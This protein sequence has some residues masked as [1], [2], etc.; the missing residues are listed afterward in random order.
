MRHKTEPPPPPPSRD[1][2]AA[3]TIASISRHVISPFQR[4]TFSLSV[5]FASYNDFCRATRLS[6]GREDGSVVFSAEKTFCT[7]CFVFLPGL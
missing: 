4:V 3:F 6:M 7:Q 2:L 1:E 5:S